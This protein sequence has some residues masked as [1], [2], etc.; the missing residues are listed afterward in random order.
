MQPWPELVGSWRQQD[1]RA[2]VVTLPRVMAWLGSVP[3]GWTHLPPLALLPQAPPHASLNFDPRSYLSLGPP[4]PGSLSSHSLQPDPTSDF[5]TDRSE[6]LGK[7]NQPLPSS[8]FNSAELRTPAGPPPP[9]EL[10]LWLNS[11]QISVCMWAWAC[12]WAS[13]FLYSGP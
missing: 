13:N 7:N 3:P 1:E 11:P 6:Q 12:V 2:S 4:P 8:Q 5:Y 10:S 9:P